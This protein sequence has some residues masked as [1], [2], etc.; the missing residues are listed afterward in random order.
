[1]STVTVMNKPP[2]VSILACHIDALTMR[3]TVARCE[4]LI[5]SGQFAQ[6][7]SLNAAKIVSLR[8]DPELKT[9]VDA[10]DVTSADGQSVVWA[11]RV[12]GQPLP[13][14]VAGIDL[15]HELLGLAERK[16]YGVY[17]LGARQAVLERAVVEIRRR[18]PNLVVAGYRDGYFSDLEGA[19]VAA[20]IRAAS[21]RLLFI[22]MSSPKKEH[23]LSRHGRATG[24]S[25][26]MGVG[27]ALDV[28]AG[29]TRRAPGWM[30]RLGLEWLYRLLQEPRRLFARYAKT[31]GIFIY[32]VARDAL[33]L[34]LKSRTAR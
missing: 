16:G 12:L 21:P 34:R 23:W 32:M 4:A 17:F 18:H 27:G 33:L 20:E 14:R 29:V 1:M 26:A 15:M 13:E 11:S 9:M 7:V 30:Q 8:G 2:R 3:D 24:A 25:F 28:V 6:Q 10:C 31:N 22:A 19:D 5:E